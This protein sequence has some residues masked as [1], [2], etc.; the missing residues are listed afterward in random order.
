MIPQ[1]KR[2]CHNFAV[3][4]T[5]NTMKDSNGDLQHIRALMERSTRFL[6]LSGLSGVSS[7]ACALLGAAVAGRY[8][9]GRPDLTPEPLAYSAGGQTGAEYW[10]PITF[11][12]STAMAVLASAL[13]GA[14]WF[15]WRRS[16]R[17]GHH[18]LDRTARRLAWNMLLPLAAGGIFCIALLLHGLPGLVAPATLVFYGL[19][20][21]HA[22]KYTFDEIRWLGLSELLL[23]LIASFRPGAG[24][25]FW[26]LGF[27]VLH[28]LYGGLMYLRHDRNDTATTP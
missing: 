25:L 15:T 7:G 16:R 13:L 19:A 21:L 18:L 3:Q 14:F 4:S 2:S 23:G 12:V 9:Q 20:L 5:L 22:S 28:I 6:G 8:L 17:L 26:A 10:G 27:G 24:L 11:L 1:G